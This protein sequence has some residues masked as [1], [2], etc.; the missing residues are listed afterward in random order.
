MYYAAA[1]IMVKSGLRDAGYDT[2][3]VTCAGWERDPVTHVLGEN[4][5]VWPRGYKAF[6]DYLHKNKLKIGAYGD[7]GEFN[8]CN[9]CVEGKCWKEPGQL[10]YEELDVQ[11]WADM[12]VDHIVIDNC[13]NANT[14]SESVFEYRKIRDALVKVNKPMIF[15]IW[16]VG[17]GKPQSWGKDSN[18]SRTAGAHQSGVTQRVVVVWCSA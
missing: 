8:C 17:D 1:D 11:T 6:I 4:K 7:T 13:Y 12:G 5:V 2:I 10:G 15:G 9:M 3:L 18:A 14:T 16:D